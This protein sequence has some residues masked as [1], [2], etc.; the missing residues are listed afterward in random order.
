MLHSMTPSQGRLKEIPNI[1]LKKNFL[2]SLISLISV[3]PQGCLV[4]KKLKNN[5]KKSNPN[6]KECLT[7]KNVVFDMNQL[8]T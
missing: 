8:N 6:K 7:L 5:L 1:A 2:H 4:L 3:L